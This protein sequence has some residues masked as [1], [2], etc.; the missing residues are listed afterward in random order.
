M[1]S[2][3]GAA[4]GLEIDEEPS[5]SEYP[6]GS[7]AATVCDRRGCNEFSRSS[8]SCP[9]PKEEGE[10]NVDALYL[11]WADGPKVD[12]ADRISIENLEIVMKNT[13]QH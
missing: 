12:S 11:Y 6:C 8:E 5:S 4:A 9:L 1:P 7:D 3:Y 13:Y 10:D 2:L